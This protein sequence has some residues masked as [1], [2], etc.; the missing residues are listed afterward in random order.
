LVAAWLLLGYAMAAPWPLNS[1]S[2]HFEPKRLVA[3][4]L[5]PACSSVARWLA[6][7]LRVRL[8]PGSGIRDRHI[9]KVWLL[10]GCSLAFPW[11]RI[12]CSLAAE[13]VIEIFLPKT[14]GCSLLAA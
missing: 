13:F 8:L 10:P 12:G 5:L 6:P 1:R 3:P 7:R 4:W 2:N 14:F 9:L 11:L